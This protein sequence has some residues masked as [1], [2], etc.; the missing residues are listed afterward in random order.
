LWSIGRLLTFTGAFEP[1]YKFILKFTGLSAPKPRLEGMT[2]G[3]F[4]FVDTYYGDWVGLDSTQPDQ[5]QEL[6]NKFV[7]CLYLPE[8]KKFDSEK[9]ALYAENADQLGEV[10][11]IAVTLNYRL[12]KEWLANLYPLLFPRP[13][14]L[15]E[16]KEKKVATKPSTTGWLNVFE[17]I[18]GDDLIHQEEY[19]NLMVHVVMRHLSKKIK[20]NGKR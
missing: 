6:L 16:P 4:M 1:W 10:E 8:R 5:K 14:D 18:V 7:G 9:I 12:L 3:Q 15:P 17:G 19:F 13:A 2:F 11:K 20:E